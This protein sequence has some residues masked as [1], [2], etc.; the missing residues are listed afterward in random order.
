MLPRS[1]SPVC[2]SSSLGLYSPLG[3]LHPTLLA[4]NTIYVP[5]IP[6][7]HFQHLLTLELQIHTQ[8]PTGPLHSCTR[9]LKLTLSRWTPTPFPVTRHL[10]HPPRCSDHRN[11]E[12]T[13][14]AFFALHVP[15]VFCR[16]DP[17]SDHRSLP[18]APA[19]SHCGLSPVTATDSSWVL[20]LLWLAGWSVFNR[21]ARLLLLKR[22]PGIPWWSSG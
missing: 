3:H 10:H 19:A 16:R 9:H 7:I 21:S 6:N 17:E 18:A 4:F 1:P 2:T 5:M 11:V 22:K 14:T 8:Q 15:S 12:L 13:C 20:P